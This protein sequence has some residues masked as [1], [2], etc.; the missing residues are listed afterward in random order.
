MKADFGNPTWVLEDAPDFCYE[1][2]NDA[3]CENVRGQYE[4]DVSLGAN[5]AF[6]AI[7]FA[8][9]LG[10]IVT[11][12]FTRRGLAFTIALSLGLIC[13][14]LGY[15]GRIMGAQNKWDSNGFLIQICCLTI[16]PAF[17]AAGLYLCLRRI[18]AV[19]GAENSRIRPEMYTRIVSP[20]PGLPS[21]EDFVLWITPEFT[22]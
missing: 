20:F 5:I 7:F 2:K 3:R 12:G 14:V 18:V 6:L 22:R 4:Y 1:H 8:S 21:T 17:M 9:L 15:G 13:E 10:F 16:G 19:F 11:Y